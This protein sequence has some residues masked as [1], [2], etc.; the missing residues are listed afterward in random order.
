MNNNVT[1]DRRLYL[2]EE[3]DRVVEEG[4]LAARYLWAAAGDVVPRVEAERLGAVVPRPADAKQA[5][6]AVN[7]MARPPENKTR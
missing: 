3:K 5:P 7:K 2:T 4:D 1:I 6:P